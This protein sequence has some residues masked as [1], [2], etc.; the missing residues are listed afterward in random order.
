MFLDMNVVMTIVENFFENQKIQV[1][2]ESGLA[3]CSWQSHHN[4]PAPDSL[5]VQ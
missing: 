2:V 5:S 3:L 1:L 4:S